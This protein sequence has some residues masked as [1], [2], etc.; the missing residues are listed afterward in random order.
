MH[1]TKD[2]IGY[3][4]G[5]SKALFRGLRSR[6]QNLLSVD[7]VLESR[8]SGGILVGVEGHDVRKSS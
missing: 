5:I 7:V 4:K 3:L 6:A 8:E 1:S 2:Q